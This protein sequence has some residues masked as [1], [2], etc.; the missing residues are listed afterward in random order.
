MFIFCRSV[1]VTQGFGWV[2]PQ[3]HCCK[4]SL[5]LRFSLL[6]W[7]VDDFMHK[8][9]SPQI[10]HP[11]WKNVCKTKTK[12][13][14]VDKMWFFFFARQIFQTHILTVFFFGMDKECWHF[15]ASCLSKL[16]KVNSLEDF[17]GLLLFLFSS[18]LI[19]FALLTLVSIWTALLSNGNITTLILMFIIIR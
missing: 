9:I 4:S 1:P 12:K 14:C 13:T 7:H 17:W 2:G 19:H 11:K 6:C 5:F 8:D 10:D 18:R 3:L 15:L 16:I